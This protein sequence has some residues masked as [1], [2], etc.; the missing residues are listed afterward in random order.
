[1]NFKLINRDFEEDLGEFIVEVFKFLEVIP[2]VKFLGWTLENDESEIPYYKYI[3]SRRKTKKKDKKI[4]YHYIK[5]D[6]A[7]QL[8]MKFMIT[9][10]DQYKIITKSILIPKCV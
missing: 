1:M 10:K 9:D 6:R 4:K 2:S 3:T 8:T 5:P 7:Q